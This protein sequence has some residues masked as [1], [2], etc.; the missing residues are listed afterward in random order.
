[1]SVLQATLPGLEKFR[2][3][4]REGAE[5]GGGLSSQAAAGGADSLILKAAVTSAIAGRSRLIWIGRIEEDLSGQSRGDSISILVDKDGIIRFV[6]RGRIIFR[7]TRRRMPSRM[8]I[9]A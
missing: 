4:W 5:G 6:H 7:R 2:E 1:M 9:I 8:R 3:V